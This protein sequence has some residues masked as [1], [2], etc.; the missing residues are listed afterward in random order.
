MNRRLT[1]LSAF[2]FSIT[3]VGPSTGEAANLTT[4]AS[5]NGTN[6]SGPV[7]IG[8]LIA[9]AD[10][11]LY[12]T[13]KFGGN[14]SLNNGQGYGTVFEVA[15][16]TNTITTLATFDGTNGSLPYAGLVADGDGNLYGTTI[17]GGTSDIGTVFKVAV[18]THELTTLYS[19]TGGM[20]G[21]L[22]IA[23]LITDGV[24]NLYGTTTQGGTN[25]N[26]T[27][28]KV[29]VATRE[30]TTLHSFTGGMDGSSPN[31]GLIADGAGN[32]YG[33]TFQGGENNIGTVFEIAV[34]TNQL[35]TLVDFNG[36]NG[37][38]PASSLTLDS[39]GN[40]YGTTANGGVNNDGTVFKIAVGTHQF[41][42]LAMFGEPNGREP[43]GGLTADASGNIYG[44]TYQGGSSD[45]G[46]AFEIVS[47]TEVVKT[48]VTFDGTNGSTP[49]GGVVA[50][51]G[52]FYGTTFGG[53]E[54]GNGTLFALSTSVPESSSLFLSAFGLGAVA[55]LCFKRMHRKLH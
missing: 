9:D 47:G 29:T 31:A 42:T 7:N 52:K 49:Y 16:G 43:V 10:G 19:F 34:G 3:L 17:Q 46:T 32:L 13:T 5:F 14:L 55:L 8:S 23:N 25:N 11:N 21:S 28:F 26:G 4:L 22:P 6:G 27:V 50:L 41:I 24:G 36:E 2:V 48:L 51:G 38:Y 35:T 12:G 40:L 37:A 15:A 18:G 44:T 1:F 39:V 33:T 53:G 54:F 45:V 20:D 30:L